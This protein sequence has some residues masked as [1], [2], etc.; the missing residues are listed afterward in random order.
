MSRILVNSRAHKRSRIYPIG[1]LK[2]RIAALLKADAINYTTP[3]E[4]V[5]RNFDF[6]FPKA[7][8]KYACRP[9]HEMLIESTGAIINHFQ[10]ILPEQW[11]EASLREAFEKMAITISRKWDQG[12]DQKVYSEKS[13]RAS[14]QHFLRWALTGGR[15]GPTLILTMGILGRDVS[16]RRIEDAATV[17]EKTTLE[18]NDSLSN[19]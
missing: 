7:R 10:E 8:E 19:P 13:F 16:L 2:D 1:E 9:R 14:V 11:G 12:S 3:L 4:F 5:E 18:A 17:L 15:P 6:F